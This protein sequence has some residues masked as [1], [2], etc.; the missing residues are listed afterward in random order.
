M[1]PVEVWHHVRGMENPADLVSRGTSPITLMSSTL[2]W[3]GPLW[4]QGLQETSETVRL[5]EQIDPSLECLRE[6]KVHSRHQTEET[7]ILVVK[8][9]AQVGISEAI[10]C[11][12]YSNVFKLL[13]VTAYVLRFVR[14]LKARFNR[15]VIVGPLTKEELVVSEVLWLREMQ[16][17]LQSDVKFTQQC[18]QL[19]VVKDENEVMRCKGR[20]G[21][22]PLQPSAKYPIWLPAK[23]HITRLIIRNCHQRVMHNGVRETLTELR[24]QYWIVKG[25]QIVRKFMGALF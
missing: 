21:N 3:K 20:L 23:H 12:D 22:S 4:L 19:G 11:E 13:R 15:D 6:M 14:N 8:G 2:W 16:A 1:L 17:S 5:P 24:S 9:S 7:A 18:I 10:R 25:R